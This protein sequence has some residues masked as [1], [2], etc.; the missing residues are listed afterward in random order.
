[1]V[2]TAGENFQST[3]E[4]RTFENKLFKNP[5]YKFA[6]YRIDNKQNKSPPA[7]PN[8]STKPIVKC[9]LKG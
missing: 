7:S 3:L 2:V 8:W 4:V 9:G 6:W 1:M 5:I